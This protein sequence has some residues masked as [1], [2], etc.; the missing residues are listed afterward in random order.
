M[1]QT[2]ISESIEIFENCFQQAIK[3]LKKNAIKGKL[4][5][6]S[7]FSAKLV[8]TNPIFLHKVC[9]ISQCQSAIFQ[10]FENL[11]RHVQAQRE[12]YLSNVL[13]TKLQ[14]FPAIY[15]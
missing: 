3:K 6:I 4:Q 1:L 12:G 9:K 2:G 5:K 8:I 15:I 7:I 13:V 14:L 10:L 11:D